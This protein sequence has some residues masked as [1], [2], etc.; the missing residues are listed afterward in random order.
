[1]K[2]PCALCGAELTDASSILAMFIPLVVDD[3][4]MSVIVCSRCA[5]HYGADVDDLLR[6]LAFDAFEGMLRGT[7]SA[8]DM[9]RA[10]QW[11]EDLPN[12]PPIRTTVAMHFA[13][14]GS[15]TIH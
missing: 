2:L 6:R 7:I 8:V 1:M 15:E 13:D 5:H 12:E 10:R 3:Q 9:S 14:H 11:L 4:S